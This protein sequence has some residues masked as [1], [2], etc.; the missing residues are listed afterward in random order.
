MSN[1]QLWYLR[2][3]KQQTA[4][5]WSGWSA[6]LTSMFKA[7]ADVEF[8]RSR[9]AFNQKSQDSKWTRMFEDKIATKSIFHQAAQ[10]TEE[11]N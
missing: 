2:V 10:A 7:I 4:L 5:P 1:G 9:S 6:R 8:T 11:T 3:N